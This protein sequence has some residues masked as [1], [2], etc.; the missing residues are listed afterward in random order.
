MS[1]RPTFPSSL[2]ELRQTCATPWGWPEI[3]FWNSKWRANQYRIP[4]PALAIRTSFSNRPRLLRHERP[5]GQLSMLVSQIFQQQR[6]NLS[7][8]KNTASMEPVRPVTGRGSVSVLGRQ[9]NGGERP[10][11]S[12]TRG[13][14]AV[15]AVVGSRARLTFEP[16][17]HPPKALLPVGVRAA[18]SSQ[19]LCI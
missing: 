4:L 2:A 12:S 3:R 9:A 15:H 11:C 8:N 16:W 7:G 10:P 6:R 14:A 13:D 18:A 5:G 19:C 1:R 17:T